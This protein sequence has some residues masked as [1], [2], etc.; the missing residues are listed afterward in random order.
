MC[1]KLRRERGSIG[2]AV[3]DEKV[4]EA[5]QGKGT[6]FGIAPSSD[7][8]R[9]LTAL[10]AETYE[11]RRA[12]VHRR[13]QVEQDTRALIGSDRQG[14]KL[15]AISYDLQRAFCMV[16]QRFAQVIRAGRNDYARRG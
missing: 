14:G 11:L 13:V 10:Y 4:K 1:G 8:W 2:L 3:R 16:A 7:L 15:A 9:A 5:Q 6:V 12:L